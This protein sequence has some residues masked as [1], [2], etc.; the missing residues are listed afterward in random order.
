MLFMTS[1]SH[2]NKDLINS[3]PRV[4][5]TSISGTRLEL[6]RREVL[7]PALDPT[8]LT[9]GMIV[10]MPTPAV[11]MAT[12]TTLPT[13]APQRKSQH[14]KGSS[15]PSDTVKDNYSLEP[16]M[17]STFGRAKEYLAR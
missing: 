5:D 15:A 11:K 12:S 9:G 8:A 4:S 10:A 13:E 17:E 14:I 16:L 2:Y 1:H 3:A 6:L 7:V